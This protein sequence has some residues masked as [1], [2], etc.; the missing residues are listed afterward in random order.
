MAEGAH[1]GFTHDGDG[2]RLLCVDERG[3]LVD[4]DQILALC[5]L[6]MLAEGRLPSRTVVATVM[7]NAGLDVSMEQA[8]IRVVR[9]P[10]GDRPVLEEMLRGRHA[11]G[12]EQ[13]GHVIF[14]EHNFTGDGIVTAL[15]VLAAMLR[16]GKPLS[17][18]AA[19]MPR[20]PQVLE[21]VRVQRK[22]DLRT[23]PAVQAKI[24][25]AERAL[26]GTGRVLVRY[27]G[28]EPLARVMVEG[29]DEA[30]IRRWAGEIA[31]AIREALG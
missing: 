26:E 19:C 18:L 30:T 3:A 8:G 6:D 13:S 17:E 7:S 16:A 25:E 2:D 20:F 11:L 4:G 9:T 21:N 29:P 1:A 27:S 24:R 28:T 22:D 23:L 15:Q 31:A 5:A 14:A 12:G 10:V